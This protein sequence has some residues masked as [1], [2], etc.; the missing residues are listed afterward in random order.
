MKITNQVTKNIIKRVIQSKDYRIEIVNLLNAEF[1]QFSIDFFKKVVAAKLNSQYITIDWY[2]T[3]F[4]ADT[5]S[6]DE[7]IIHSGLNEKTI[8]N[9]YGT[10]AKSAVIDASSEHFET[11]YNSIQS[12]VENE[13]NE[14]D[15]T[16]TIKLKGVSVDLSISESLIVIN[17]LAVKRSQIR[18]GLWST[19]GKS[20]EK[21]LMLSL[22]QLYQVSEIHYDSS[23]FV[24]DKSKKVDREID[25]YLIDD[26][27]QKYL[28]EV[29]L[30]GAGNP[31]SADAIIAR[32]SHVFVADTLSQQNK[33]Q[34]DEL[35][36]LW[37]ALRE[38]QGFFKFGTI[39][40]QLNIP[41]QPYQ[42]ENHEKL[43]R[44]LDRILDNL[45]D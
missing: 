38:P 4:L 44:D 31:E 42:Y 39:L 30:M 13:Q 32:N 17:T 16:L 10:T 37:V 33:N 28:C 25:F 14:I 12:L 9:M 27:K 1:L 3:Y 2:K 34:C 15:L 8:K 35:G 22:C 20:V 5:L 29:K 7:I 21:Y 40:Q 43:N 11:L 24:K 41:Y 23:T 36:V 6:K 26:N 18:G 45:L 19:A